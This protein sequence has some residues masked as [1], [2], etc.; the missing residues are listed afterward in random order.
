MQTTSS[1]NIKFTGNPALFAFQAPKARQVSLAG[2]FNDWDTQAAPMQ[3]GP[4]DIWRLSV[5]LR[6]GRYEYRFYTD[7]VWRDDPS[8]PQ[9]AA[10][11]LGTQN[12]V[13][14][15]AKDS[16]MIETAKNAMVAAIKGTGDVV[17]ATVYAITQT[18]ATTLKNTGHVGTSVTDA[19]ADVASG[20]VRAT[21]QAGADMGRAAQGIMLG[22]LRGTKEAGA[23]VLGTIRHTAHVAIRDTAVVGGDLEVAATGLVQGAIAGAKELGVS[24]ED[25]AAAAASGALK[26]AG[27]VSATA[28]KT[29]RKAFTKT[30]Q[31]VK[32]VAKE[33]EAVLV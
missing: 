15:I 28:L 11:A 24:A 9:R 23:E 20:A 16:G 21:V 14:I 2:D 3:K 32:V 29:V 6:P 30:I 33:P 22:V 17:Q 13:R 12:C 25:A 10:N 8:A 1:Q 19:V 18:L 26:G 5:P 27:E 31:G 7:G 4:D